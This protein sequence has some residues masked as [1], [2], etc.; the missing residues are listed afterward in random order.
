MSETERIHQKAVDQL[1]ELNKT[2]RSMCAL[3]G[4][5]TVNQQIQ[6]AIDDLKQQVEEFGIHQLQTR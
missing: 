6:L 2:L 1:S 4:D 5:W 3:S